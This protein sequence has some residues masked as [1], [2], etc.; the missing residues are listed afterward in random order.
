MIQA[1]PN[2]IIMTNSTTE[3]TTQDSLVSIVEEGC[4][5]NR[6]RGFSRYSDVSRN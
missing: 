5:I 3:A 6:A 2:A 4:S 1:E